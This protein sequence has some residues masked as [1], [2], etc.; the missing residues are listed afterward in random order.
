LRITLRFASPAPPLLEQANHL[1]GRGVPFDLRLFEHR[2]PVGDDLEASTTRRHELD[3]SFR[4]PLTNLGRQPDGPR[5]VASHRA[6]FNGDCHERFES[7]D[8][9]GGRRDSPQNLAA[10]EPA[11]ASCAFR[12]RCGVESSGGW[13][14]D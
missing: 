2:D 9:N 10:A 8:S 5:L 1:A 11:R 4:E 13:N 7:D 3:L 12:H 6:V 14:A